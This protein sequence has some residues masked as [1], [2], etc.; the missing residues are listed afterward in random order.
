MQNAAKTMKLL[1]ELPQYCELLRQISPPP[2]SSSLSLSSYY[3]CFYSAHPPNQLPWPNSPQIDAVFHH[4]KHIAASPI[5]S[6]LPPMPPDAIDDPDQAPE[7]A[8]SS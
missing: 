6:R 3:L 8:L 2:V 1:T 7:H 4:P 5:S